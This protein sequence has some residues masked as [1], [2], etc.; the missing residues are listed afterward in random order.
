VLLARL[1]ILGLLVYA[2]AVGETA[3]VDA[4][5]VRQVA[6]SLIALAAL[7]WQLAWPGP[8]AFLG[9]GVIALAGDLFVPGRIGLGAAAMLIVAYAT[10]RLRDRLRI[11][12]YAWQIPLIFAATSVWATGS[13]VLR[14]MFG[15]AAVGV[16]MLGQS[17]LVGVYT[18]LLAL[19]VLMVLAWLRETSSGRDTSGTSAGAERWG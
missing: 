7:T 11:E 16:A 19:P 14:A 2:A 13:G 12:H 4:L 9:A 10:G 15:E 18:A 17:L 6:P 5:A 8:Y 3:M 1:A